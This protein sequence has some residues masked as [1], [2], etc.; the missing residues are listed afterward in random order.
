MIVEC[1]CVVFVS[2]VYDLRMCLYD[3]RMLVYDFRM[4]LSTYDLCRFVYVFA[5]ALE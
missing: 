5:Y 2:C 1:V 3:F 4:R